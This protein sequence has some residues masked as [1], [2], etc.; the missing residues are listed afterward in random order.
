MRDAETLAPQQSDCQT[1]ER[2]DLRQSG[3][4]FRRRRDQ[5]QKD[6]P[7]EVTLQ[8]R[9]GG[10]GPFEPPGGGVQSHWQSLTGGE[11]KGRQVDAGEV[12]P[13][14]G[15]GQLLV[16]AWVQTPRSPAL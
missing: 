11:P 5:L 8:T 13:V 7:P 10:Q 4:K 1:L 14:G 16:Q 3:T 2:A 9:F 6:L 12:E 15:V